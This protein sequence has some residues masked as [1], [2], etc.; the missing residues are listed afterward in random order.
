MLGVLDC[1]MRAEPVQQAPEFRR[2][3]C[4]RPHVRRRCRLPGR[5]P[6]GGLHAGGLRHRRGRGCAPHG[7]ADVCDPGVSERLSRPVQPVNVAR[8]RAAAV[9]AVRAVVQHVCW[10]RDH[11]VAERN[12]A[13][14]RVARRELRVHRPW[15]VVCRARLPQHICVALQVGPTAA[16]LARR[17]QVELRRERNAHG[18]G[19]YDC[20][21]GTLA[22]HGAQ[23]FFLRHDEPRL[24]GHDPNICT[25]CESAKHQQL[26]HWRCLDI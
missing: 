13:D 12:A 1:A 21:S 11:S 15:S 10:H 9:L 17:S 8:W 24:L 18:M 19:S 5:Q 20:V 6:G 2:P 16:V 7:P 3:V 4:W 25:C 14:A 22:L 26:C 23:R